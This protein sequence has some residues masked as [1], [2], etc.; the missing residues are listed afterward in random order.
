MGQ[1]EVPELGKALY[2]YYEYLARVT[3]SYSLMMQRIVPLERELTTRAKRHSYNAGPHVHAVAGSK[4]FSTTLA[5]LAVACILAVV[6]N[7][8]FWWWSSAGAQSVPGEVLAGDR[9]VPPWPGCSL[10]AAHSPRTGVH[11]LECWWPCSG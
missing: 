5:A 4:I 9:Q 8:L 10:L 3:A 6:L 11:R 2:V 7:L 1:N